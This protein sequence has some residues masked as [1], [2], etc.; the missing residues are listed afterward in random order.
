MYDRSP[1]YSSRFSVHGNQHLSM[2]WNTRNLSGVLLAASSPGFLAPLKPGPLHSIRKSQPHA[3]R[4]PK[5]SYPTSPAPV[6][7]MAVPHRR[8][9]YTSHYRFSKMPV[10]RNVLAYESSNPKENGFAM[11]DPITNN[12]LGLSG[13]S[14]LSLSQRQGNCD[15]LLRQTP[16][17]HTHPTHQS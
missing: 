4:S 7:P 10:T 8:T 17:S 13:A 14:C 5:S 11:I 16:C 12:K 1:R 3:K 9:L 2:S 6:R 15:V